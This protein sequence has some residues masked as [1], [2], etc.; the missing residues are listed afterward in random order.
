MIDMALFIVWLSAIAY[1]LFLE[2]E[3]WFIFV[4]NHPALHRKYV[5]VG[6]WWIIPL[7]QFCRACGAEE[8]RAVFRSDPQLRWRFRAFFVSL[9]LYALLIPRMLYLSTKL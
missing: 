4:E 3:M 2:P 1:S 7:K 9:A 8:V 6:K 5:P